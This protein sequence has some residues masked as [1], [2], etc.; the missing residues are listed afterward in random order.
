MRRAGGRFALADGRAGTL[1]V[2]I[3][4]RDAVLVALEGVIDPELRK[5]VTELEMVRDVVVHPD[6]GVDVTIALTVVGCPLRSSFEEQ[7][8]R[9]VGGL[10]HVTSVRL[11]FDV[12]SPDEKKAL[13]SRLRGGRPEKS[14]QL[15]PRTRVIAVCSGKGGVGKSTL[16]AN[17]AYALSL[18]GEDVGVLDADVYGHSIPHVLG[19]KQRPVVVDELIVPPVNWDLKLFSIGFFTEENAPIMWRGP[20]LH[21]FLEQ[22]LSDVHWGDID[23]LVVDMPPGTGDVSISLGQLLPRADVLVVTTPQPAAQ[24][25]AVRAAQMAEKTGMRIAGVV[26]N[27]SWLVGTGQ[28]IFGEG[29]GEALANEVGAPLLARIP[30]DPVLREAADAGTPVQAVAPESEAAVAI[31]ALAEVVQAKR[32]GTIRKA[33]TVLS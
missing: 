19:I 5:P 26:E 3:A 30:L 31:A 11:H 16:A 10:D 13:A 21:R 7:V 1:E 24:L 14:V 9:C 33:L 27:M 20:M 8:Q 32:A 28:T 23:T 6:G 25:V 17:L 15:D 22:A 2:M 29:G 4:D 18:R 12:M